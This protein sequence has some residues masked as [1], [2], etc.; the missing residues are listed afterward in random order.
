MVADCELALCMDVTNAGGA[1]PRVDACLD[2]REAFQTVLDV[3]G[4][5]AEM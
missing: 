1:E 2:F 3:H 4:S 5:C